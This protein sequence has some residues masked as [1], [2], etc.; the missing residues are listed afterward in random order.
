[1]VVMTGMQDVGTNPTTG[2]RTI[3][4]ANGDLNIGGSNVD[5]ATCTVRYTAATKTLQMYHWT[6]TAVSDTVIL[7]VGD[8]VF[9]NAPWANVTL[10]NGVQLYSSTTI[11]K[12]KKQAGI[13]YLKGSVKN[14]TTI[15]LAIGTLPAG[16]RP[17][18]TGHS[19]AAPTSGKNYAR[20][21][22]GT[23]GV[24]SLENVS[25][26]GNPTAADWFCVDTSFTTDD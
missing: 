9:Q 1:V 20:W 6:G 15:G 13:V 22:I 2:K 7:K 19:F 5:L 14:I 11:V 21:T 16:Y 3:F 23:D 25:Q 12:Y 18:T 24:I 4:N 10:T 8:I 26:V 17:V